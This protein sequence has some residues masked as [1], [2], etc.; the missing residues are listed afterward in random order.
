MEKTC[1]TCV[2][3]AMSYAGNRNRRYLAGKCDLT[4]QRV[5]SLLSACLLYRS[6][7]DRIETQSV[8]DESWRS[9]ASLPLA[10]PK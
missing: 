5:S 7:Q 8:K 9:G 4:G 3:R 1:Q 6:E 2:W 10:V